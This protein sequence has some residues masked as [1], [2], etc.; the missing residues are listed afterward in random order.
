MNQMQHNQGSYFYNQVLSNNGN[1]G[2]SAQHSQVP[3]VPPPNFYPNRNGNN[4][5]APYLFMARI[6]FRSTVAQCGDPKSNSTLIDSGGS[7][8]FFHSMSSFVNYER[9]EKQDVQAASEVSIPVDKAQLF[10]A[11]AGG[12]YVGRIMHHTLRRTFFP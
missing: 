12:I 3:D 8:H 4:F 11:I 2:P 5:P 9:S 6:K 1:A 10:V 7:H